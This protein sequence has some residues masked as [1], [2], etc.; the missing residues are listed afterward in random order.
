[1]RPYRIVEI[2]SILAFRPAGWCLSFIG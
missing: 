1:M 2:R